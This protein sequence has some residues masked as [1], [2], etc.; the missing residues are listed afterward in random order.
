MVDPS[1]DMLEFFAERHLASLTL[2]RPNG[3]P[4]VTPVGFTWDQVAGLAR[5]I[6]WSGSV[7]ARLLEGSGPLEA[8][9]CQVDGGRWVTLLGLAEVS[10]DSG[11]CAEAVRRYASRYCEPKD[12]GTE[13][14][15]IE[16]QVRRLLG[17]A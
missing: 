15:V 8:A 14:R 17:R 10:A 13:R 4:H 9:I 16:I 1:P 2:V 7:K 5:V 12:R 3:L 6:T 11:R